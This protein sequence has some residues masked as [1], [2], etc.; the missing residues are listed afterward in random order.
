M[1]FKARQLAGTVLV[2]SLFIQMQIAESGYASRRTKIAFTSSPEGNEGNLDIYVMDDDGRNL[3]RV[4][5]HPGVDDYPAWSPDGKKIAFVSKR[6]NVNKDHRQIWVIDADGKNP[7]RLTD[8]MIDVFPDWSP[9]GTKIVYETHPGG[10]TVMDADGN[11]KRLVKNARGFHP[12]WSPDGE[13]IAFIAGKNPGDGAQIYVMDVDGQNRRQ[14]THDPVHKRL[15]SWSNDGKRI[16][17]VGNNVIWVVDS[18]GENQRQLTRHVT[19]EH[20]TWSPDSESIAFNS[21]GREPGI[22]G[23]YTVDVT[24]GAVDVLLSDPGTWNFDPDW[25]Y[26]GGLSVSPEGSRIRIWG[27][28]KKLASNLR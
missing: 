16:A 2:V 28:M 17:Y 14:L 15:P 4:T 22:R 11:N 9:D 20:P 7:M 19:E 27:R 10:I 6:N 5:V 23:I 21:F 13:R 25:L 24:S 26:P 8:G 12:T 1:T 18:D 3:R